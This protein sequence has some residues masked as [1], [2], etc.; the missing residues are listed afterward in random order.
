MSA[1]Q[2]L[3]ASLPDR[4]DGLCLLGLGGLMAALARS[5]LY[6]YFL[7]PKFSHLTLGAGAL[8]CLT[9]LALLIL[10][11]QGRF[12]KGRLLRQ[13]ALAAFVALAVLAWRDA[14][15][16]E[17]APGVF[18][19]APKQNAIP[20]PDDDSKVDLKPVV[21]GVPHVRLNLAELY[22]MLDKGR[23]DY[24]AHFALRA[25]VM[26][27]PQLDGRGHVLLRRIAVV[28]C[29]AD[30]LDLRFL[31]QPAAGGEPLSD[32][33]WVE[34]FGH[35]E[36][37]AA[38]PETKGLLKLAP[39]G[40]GPGLAITNPKFRIVAERVDRIKGPGFPYLFEFREKE[41]FAW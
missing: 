37:L 35:L 5:N 38:N 11:R 12:T 40:Q 18:D 24:P 2:N 41:P 33:E 10:P 19:P 14:A 23:K 1:L 21:D 29:L 3:K 17:A 16:E 25:Q 9:G 27:T 28:C 22:I 30:S 8:L 6:W 20:E 15:R 13:A 32:G 26:R 31:T 36:P 7:N 39:K 4:M 34:V